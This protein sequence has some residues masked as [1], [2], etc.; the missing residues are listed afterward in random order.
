MVAVGPT[1]LQM[2]V[3]VVGAPIS[4]GFHRREKQIPPSLGMTIFKLLCAQEIRG[5]VFEISPHAAPNC[6]NV[7]PI[8]SM[9]FTFSSASTS[10][11]N[12]GAVGAE[13]NNS[14]GCFQSIEPFPGHRCEARYLG[15][16]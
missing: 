11:S 4:K 14:I 5:L 2:P 9:G 6:R 15:L 13:R 3:M 16:S 10:S 8:F 7:S 1:C 12:G